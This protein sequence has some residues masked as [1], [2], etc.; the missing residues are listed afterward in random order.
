[1]ELEHEADGVTP[2]PVGITQVPEIASG[3]LQVAGVGLVE[4]REQVEQRRLPRA[5]RAGDRDPL[6]RLDVEVDA[7]QH[8]HPGAP[9]A[10]VHVRDVDLTHGARLPTG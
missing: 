6:P 9:E 5:R 3:H 4:R 8:L 7:G 2:V 1:M 10:L